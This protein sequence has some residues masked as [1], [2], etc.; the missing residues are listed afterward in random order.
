MMDERVYKH[1]C[2]VMERYPR[3][4]KCEQSIIFAYQ[5]LKEGYLRGGKLLV[6]GNGGSAAD[7]EHMAGELMKGFEIDREIP[8]DLKRKLEE[9]DP[10]R[11]KNLAKKLHG[12]LPAIPLVAHEAMSTAYLNDVDG[13]GIFA[14]QLYGFGKP[15][16]I[17]LGIS[18]SGNSENVLNAAV[19]AKALGIPVIGLTGRDG[20][21]LA[22]VADAVVRV[23]ED[24][25]CLVQELHLPVYHCWCLMLES[26]F[27]GD[28]G[29]YDNNENT[30]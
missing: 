19:V 1:V 5:I 17:F 23:P 29:F 26:C 3:L 18:T 7:S 11:G 14:Q 21:I 15:E 27:W 28:G 13:Q 6:A 16:D 30:V 22:Q 8:L 12:A 24:R 25:P 10:I 20:G 9:T 2:G 4:K